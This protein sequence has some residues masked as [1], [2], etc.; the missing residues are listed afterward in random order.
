MQEGGVE[1]RPGPAARGTNGDH[2][3][4]FG[5]ELKRLRDAARLT[6][7]ELASSRA[8]LT[9]KAVSA[10]E[11]DVRKR[12]YPHTVRSLT[13]A[14]DLTDAERAP[15]QAAVPVRGEKVRAPDAGAP[16]R[17]CARNQV[18]YEQAQRWL[19]ENLVLRRELGDK[20][21]T[22]EVL[23]NLGTVTFDRGDYPR[24]TALEGESLSLWRKL[25]DR[26][27]ITL[28]LNNLGIT[29]RTQGDLAEAASLHEESLDLFRA[30]EDT[31]G[32]AL[33]LSNLGGVAER[34]GQY[35]KAA[36]FYRESLDL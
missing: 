14:L 31:G 25:G 6:Q 16:P 10:L 33:V 1:D 21:G 17:S 11:R 20:K 32:I 4:P 12:P 36:S 35:T 9:A 22:A 30:L 3:A 13:D 5:A 2:E 29:M 34:R 28:A 8:G 26:W 19:E 27:G 7:E 18:D 24:S 23:I 15:L